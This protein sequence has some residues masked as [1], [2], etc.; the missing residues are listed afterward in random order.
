MWGFAAE[1][2]KELEDRGAISADEA[3]RLRTR[4]KMHQ[5]EAGMAA[6][7]RGWADKVYGN[8]W[9]WGFHVRITFA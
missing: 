6:G 4:G 9:A 2:A 3:R 5:Q 1:H 8:S 7:S